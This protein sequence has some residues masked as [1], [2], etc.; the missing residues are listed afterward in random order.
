[1]AILINVLKS[2]ADEPFFFDAICFKSQ[3]DTLSRIDIYVLVPYGSLSFFKTGDRYV[4]E[5]DLSISLKDSTGK[6]LKSKSY[7]K[8]IREGTTRNDW[9]FGKIPSFFR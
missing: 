6:S 7:P 4:A 8:N 9:F 1:L 3:I 5:F 2:K